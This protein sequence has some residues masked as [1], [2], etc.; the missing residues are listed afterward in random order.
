[1]LLSLVDSLRCPAGHEGTSLVLSVESWSGKRVSEGLLGCPLCH[2][3]Y[4]IRQGAVDFT[5][6]S[7]DVRHMVSDASVDVMRLAAQLQLN[8]PGGIVLLTGRYRRERGSVAEFP[9]SRPARRCVNSSSR[10][11]RTSRG[12]RDCRW[13]MRATRCGD[14]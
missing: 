4:P 6:G 9:M 11:P 2:A 1:M 14:R 8:E 12:T 3:R 7:S 5:G 13:S 10:Q